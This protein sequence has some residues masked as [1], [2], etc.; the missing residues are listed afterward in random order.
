MLDVTND[1]SDFELP[2]N[3]YN[4]TGF[5]GD[6]FDTKR[7]IRIEILSLDSIKKDSIYQQMV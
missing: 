7:S 6:F 4:E 1:V 5:L 2:F 3:I